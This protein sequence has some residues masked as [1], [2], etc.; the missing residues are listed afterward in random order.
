[1]DIGSMEPMVPD[2]SSRALDDDILPLVAEANQLA[3]RSCVSRSGIW[4]GR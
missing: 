4:F 3:G 2:E 1:M